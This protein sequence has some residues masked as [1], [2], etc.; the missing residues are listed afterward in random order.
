MTCCLIISNRIG[1][2]TQLIISHLNILNYYNLIKKST[3]IYYT[4]ACRRLSTKPTGFNNKSS[5][6]NAIRTLRQGR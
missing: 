2:N 1:I 6:F 4:L 5:I 3:C